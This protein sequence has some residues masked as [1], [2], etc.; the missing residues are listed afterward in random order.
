MAKKKIAILDP[1]SYLFERAT[2]LYGERIEHTFA[3]SVRAAVEDLPD[4]HRAAIEMRFWGRMT[5]QE[6]ADIMGWPGRNYAHQYYKRGMR[7]LRKL[8]TDRGVEYEDG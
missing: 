6:I 8:L 5:Y 2:D 4:K 3:D 1:G 7:K